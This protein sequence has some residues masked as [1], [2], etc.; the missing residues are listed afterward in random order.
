MAEYT[1]RRA[2]IEN[3]LEIKF[4]AEI[5]N[6]IPALFDSD[7]VVNEQMNQDRMKFLKACKEEDFFD[8]VLAD[9]K[10][11][12]A[13]H[14]VKKVP[15][16]DRFAGRID[17]LWIAPDHRKKGLAAA[18][19]LRAEKWAQ[20][21]GLDHLHTWVHADNRKMIS[22]NEKM[23]YRTVNYKMRKDKKDFLSD[24]S[25][26]NDDQPN[27]QNLI[28]LVAYNPE[29]PNWFAQIS[30]KLAACLDGLFVSID[31]IG[32]TSIPGLASKDRIDV[33]ITVQKIDEKFKEKLDKA[34][35]SDGFKE[36]RWEQ[37][38][39][40]PGDESP[41]ENWKK[42]YLSGIHPELSFRANIHV[43]VRGMK[44]QIY[45][46][47]FRD[48][49]RAH[50]DSALAYQRVKEELV[51]FHAND[52]IAYTEL[53]DPACDLIMVNAHKWAKQTDW[54]T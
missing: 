11:I 41:Q 29:W 14:V 9:N 38:H 33:Q 1:F 12:V 36:S 22:L 42:L 32:S 3:D 40:P 51:R 52:S 18:L 2:S 50:P 19:K 7:F 43:R 34:L 39:R 24:S 17:T 44:N 23:G 13:F 54:K 5:D 30:K 26:K 46:I 16:F 48:Y 47:L 15:H 10:N 53:K 28:Q 25:K 21:Q 37:D 35:T 8:V 4:I 31:H 49:L 27:A 45:P 20:E 6:T